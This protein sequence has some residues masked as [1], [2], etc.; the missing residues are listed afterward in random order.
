MDHQ[1]Q[2]LFYF[3]LEAKSF[4]FGNSHVFLVVRSV[5]WTAGH[6]GMTTGFSRHV[7]VNETPRAAA[8]DAGQK[9]SLEGKANW[10]W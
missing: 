5:K 8:S 3:R 7:F 6:M 10:E 9:G 1:V 2:Q 4:F